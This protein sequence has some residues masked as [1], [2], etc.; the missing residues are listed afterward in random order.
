MSSQ[1]WEM[2]WVILWKPLAPWQICWCP[3]SPPDIQWFGG[4]SHEIGLSFLIHLVGIPQ[5][6]AFHLPSGN[7]TSSLFFFHMAH[8]NRWFTVLKDGDFP[9]RTTPNFPVR[10][11][12]LIR[13][14]GVLRTGTLCVYHIYPRV[15][16]QLFPTEA[17]TP[18]APV[19]WTLWA[20]GLATSRPPSM[21]SSWFLVVKNDL[22]RFTGIFLPEKIS[23]HI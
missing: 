1:L 22:G 5:S 21:P 12:M 9:V 11:C 17:S 23:K 10:F 4:Q 16:I 6:Q 15:S 20:L 2:W 3:D 13:Q 14:F 8:R 7:L 19:W 18:W